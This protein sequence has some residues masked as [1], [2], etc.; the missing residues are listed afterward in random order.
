MLRITVIPRDLS[1][2]Q[3]AP[4]SSPLTTSAARRLQGANSNRLTS[5]SHS[6]RRTPPAP[7][8]SSFLPL[9]LHTTPPSLFLPTT[10][11]TFSNR[12]LSTPASRRSLIEA[13]R[14]PLDVET[15]QRGEV[16]RHSTQRAPASQSLLLAPSRYTTSTVVY[17]V[18]S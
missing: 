10:S 11:P 8:T 9:A 6:P 7:T 15:S 5:S 12:S 13:R 14:S 1:R 2:S 16:K 17:R 4:A 3:P 18:S